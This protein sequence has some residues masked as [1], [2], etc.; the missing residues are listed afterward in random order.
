M[1]KDNAI[2]KTADKR[3]KRSGQKKNR[4]K[5]YLLLLVIAGVIG[6]IISFIKFFGTE[7]V[8]RNSSISIE[9]TYD[10]AAQNKTP[11]GE[12][13][14][15]S[16]LTSDEV[17]EK[18]L[19]AVE[20]SDKYTAEDIRNSITISGQYPSDVIDQI[21]DFDSL[22]DFSD[23]RS[24][25]LNNYYPTVY[26]VK[27]YDDF[28]SS[29]SDSKMNKLLNAIAEQ[30]K[31]Y[32]INK[33]TYSY[34]TSD[35]NRIHSISN[36]DYSQRVKILKNRMSMLEK[37]AGEMYALNTN[38]K[39]NG[40][41]FND[42]L[43]KSR[44]LRN[45]SLD[46]VEAVVMTDVLTVSALRLRNQYEYEIKLLENEKKYKAAN[47]ED[48]NSLINIYEMD[49]DLYVAGNESMVKVESNSQKTY[50]SLMQEK[51]TLSERIVQIDA[52]I[53]KFNSY[54]DDLKNASV[55]AAA[56][57]KTISDRID[58]INTK[59]TE[60]E[61]T[62]RNMLTEYNATIIDTD[63]V[64][65]NSVRNNGASLFSGSFILNFIKCAGPLCIVVIIVCALH[66]AWL[67]RK[68]F[69]K[70]KQVNA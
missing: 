38:F 42:L 22:Y 13:F 45:D 32:F 57:G 30:Y 24:V 54:L 60:I 47:I 59:L 26:S 3:V 1:N 4:F 12:Q 11:S 33:Y 49:A 7:K 64:L 25:S 50:E 61:D 27:L 63:S 37:Y 19:A 58:V 35:Y 56:E 17:L 28:D 39:S 6:L 70:E 29:I 51:D 20:L 2:N 43:L 66:A 67:E 69:L 16:G 41:S 8:K 34:D 55:N 65:L 31:E 48:I 5:T 46:N 23:S 21:K 15:I 40:L 36:Y 14:S 44:S 10:G 18:A 52:E 9:F 68:K 53:N 62:F